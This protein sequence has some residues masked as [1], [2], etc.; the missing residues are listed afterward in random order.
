MD[1]QGK[2]LSEK[3]WL[4]D[5]EKLQRLAVMVLREID[6]ILFD[7]DFRREMLI[8]LWSKDRIRM[9]LLR[10]LHSRYFELSFELL[11]LFPPR[12]F[13]LLDEF[14]RALDSF[15][16]YASYTEDMPQSLTQRFETFFSDLKDKAGPLMEQL[17]ACAPDDLEVQM[18]SGGPPPLVFEG[19][20][21]DMVFEDTDPGRLIEGLGPP[22]GDE[23][24]K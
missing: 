21:A 22:V 16:F 9:P 3:K 17:K 8:Q 13:Q 6:R 7:L 14:Y 18:I 12:T 4:D 23:E 19:E 15:T 20:G 10:V 5:E 24:K 11:A 1:L 2:R